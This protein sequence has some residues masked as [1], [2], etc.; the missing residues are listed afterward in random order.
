[1]GTFGPGIFENDAAL[2]ASADISKHLESIITEFLDDV[3]IE[4]TESAMGYIAILIS[5]VRDCRGVPPESDKVQTWQRAILGAY[6]AEIDDLDPKPGYKEARRAVLEATFD[7][8]L[9]L[10]QGS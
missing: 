2:D 1:V 9:R 8:L 4:D 10:A 3:Q 5:V 6:D 7:E